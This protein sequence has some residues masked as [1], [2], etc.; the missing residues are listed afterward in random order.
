MRESMSDRAAGCRPGVGP[1]VIVGGYG[2]VGTHV[3]RM[4][5]RRHPDLTLVLA[6]RNPLAGR[7]LAAALGARA[8]QVDAGEER[9]LS[10]L[11]ERPAAILAA[12]SDPADRLILDAMRQGIPIADIDRGGSVAALDVALRATRERPAAPVLMSGGWMGGLAALLGSALAREAVSPSRIELTV[13]AS[14]ADRVGA[15]AWG[16]SRRWAWTYHVQEHGARRVA[17]PLTEVRRVRCPDGRERPSVRVGT[18]EQVTLPMT[19]AVPAVEGRLAMQAGHELWGLV[20][21]KRSGALRALERPRLQGLRRRLLQRSGAGDLTGF[22]LVVTGTRGTFALDVLDVRGQAHLTAVGAV[23]AA[24]RVLGLTETRL[25]PGV[26]FPEQTAWSAGDLA[27]LTAAGVVLR[28]H[29]FTLTDL[30][31]RPSDAFET[32]AMLGAILKEPLAT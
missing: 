31:P 11:P 5:R 16:F 15:D 19:L 28:P 12:T 21:L 2:L 14:S 26:S 10:R 22:S 25:P 24:E 4:L 29:G 6:G 20:A 1:L 3:A 30:A 17:H 32:A 8:A 13:L 27:A 18:L 23:L 7:S 9:P